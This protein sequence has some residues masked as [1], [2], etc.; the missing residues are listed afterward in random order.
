MAEKPIFRLLLLKVKEAGYKLLEDEE[1]WNE[2]LKEDTKNLEELGG[3]HIIDCDCRWSSGEWAFFS[4][5]KFPDI[6]AVQKHVKYEEEHGWF[7]YFEYKF[8]LGTR[9]ELP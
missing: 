3:K 1:K 5:S 6:E 2:L 4:V 7:R 9:Y 8:C